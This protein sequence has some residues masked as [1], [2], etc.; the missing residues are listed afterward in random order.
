[1][2]IIFNTVHVCYLFRNLRMYATCSFQ[3]PIFQCIS[4]F[5]QQILPKFLKYFNKHFP[6]TDSGT[7]SND[8]MINI[9]KMNNGIL[10]FIYLLHFVK[11]GT[12]CNDSVI[13]ILHEQYIENE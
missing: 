3:K 4:K 6:N 12:S 2:Y 8:S 1:M 13:N 9:L 7:S 10:I 5:Q 11:S